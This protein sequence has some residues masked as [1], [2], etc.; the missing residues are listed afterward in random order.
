VDIR[1]PAP[2]I[3]A[4]PPG[5]A[6]VGGNVE[7]SQRLVDLLLAAAGARAASQGTMNNLTLGGAG[8]S[9]YETLGGGLGASPLGAGRSGGQVHMTNTRAT[10]PEVL[11]A[12]LPLRVRRFALRPG[13]GGAGRHRGGDG[14][15]RELELTC[16]ATASLLATRREAGAPGHAG[17]EA[18]APG[19]DAIGR[20]DLWERWDGQAVAL[21]A[22]DRVRVETPGGGGW[23]SSSSH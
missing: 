1:V 11:E 3:L 7:T 21:M 2:S 4:P 9:L 19:A 17:G 13:S 16:P 18:G 12:R 14:L 23:G 22:G 20:G 15:I 8:W 10:D 6:V 5:A